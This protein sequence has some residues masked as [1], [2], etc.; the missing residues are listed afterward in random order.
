MYGKDETEEELM[1][2]PIASR[3]D[4]RGRCDCGIGMWGVGGRM[5]G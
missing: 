1:C 4:S 5:L 3:V 2:S